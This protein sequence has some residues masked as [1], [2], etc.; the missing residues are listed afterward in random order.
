MLVLTGPAITSAWGQSSLSLV[1]STD[2][3]TIWET[4]VNG[5]F[6]TGPLGTNRISNA[7]AATSM[8]ATSPTGVEGAVAMLYETNDQTGQCYVQFSALFTAL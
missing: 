8:T 7:I 5:N 3:P 1:P 6:G 4:F 2:D